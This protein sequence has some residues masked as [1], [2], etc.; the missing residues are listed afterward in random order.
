MHC[1]TLQRYTQTCFRKFVDDFMIVHVS[2][3]TSSVLH[4]AQRDVV[5]CTVAV[6]ASS[7]RK[8]NEYTLTHTFR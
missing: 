4:L 3:G 5:S 1:R 8:Q 2:R 7:P 6:A